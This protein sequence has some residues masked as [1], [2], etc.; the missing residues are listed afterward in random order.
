MHHVEQGLSIAVYGTQD[1]FYA[2]QFRNGRQG[3]IPANA[4]RLAR[5]LPVHKFVAH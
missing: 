2:A 1:G 3:W 4:V 5:P